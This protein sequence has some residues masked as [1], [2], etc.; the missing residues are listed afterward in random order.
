MDTKRVL[1]TI[2]IAVAGGATL[3]QTS[4][5]WERAYATYES[6]E[7]SPDACI[8]IDTYKPFWV[9]PSMFH[10]IPDPDPT[11]RYGLGMEWDFPIFNRAYEVSTGASLGETI[12]YDP[13][14][15]PNFTYWG[16]VRT[17]GRRIV[18]TNGFLLVDS[19][20]CADAATLERLDA[21]YKTGKW[22]LEPSLKAKPE[23]SDDRRERADLPS[24]SSR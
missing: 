9:L 2:V 21:Y 6:S 20:R 3:Y 12:V 1:V 11:I 23:P 22:T 24:D 18:K 10:R 5:W 19:N 17:P 8:R 4:N 7:T 16:D 14:S 13:Q 15:A